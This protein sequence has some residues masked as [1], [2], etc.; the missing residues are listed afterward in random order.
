[1]SQSG[2]CTEHSVLLSALLRARGFPTRLADGVIVDGTH[3][4]YHEWVEVYVDGEGFI[5][6]DPTFGQF[7]AG[8]ERLKLAEGSTSPDEHLTLSVAAARLLKPGVKIE[9]LDATK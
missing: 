9:V 8:P 5:P 3:A 2:D 4:G 6:T 7:P 1:Q